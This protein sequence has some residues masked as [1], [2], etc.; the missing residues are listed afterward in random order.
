[1]GLIIDYNYWG[2]R[3]GADTAVD[4]QLDGAIFSSL[5]RFNTNYL[6][7]YLNQL[8]GATNIAGSSHTKLDS[9]PVTRHGGEE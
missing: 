6:L 3:A 4:F 8:L 7:S 5:A 9:M 1:M 2:L